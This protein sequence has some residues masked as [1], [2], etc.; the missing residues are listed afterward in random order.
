MTVRYAEHRRWCST[1][2]AGTTCS[3]GSDNTLQHRWIVDSTGFGWEN[4]G[5]SIAG[6]PTVASSAPGRIDV[7]ARD[8]D[9]K[10]KYIAWDGNA[11][12]WTNWR[13]VSRDVVQGTPALVSDSPNHLDVYWR[14]GAD[15]LR[16]A[17]FDGT[18]W[19]GATRLTTRLASDPAVISWGAG[20]VDVFWRA[21]GN[22]LMHRG[23]D[24]STIETLAANLGGKPAVESWGAG[25][26]DV[27]WRGTDDHAY[28]MAFQNRWWPAQDLGGILTADPAV[29]SRSVGG[30]EAYVRGVGN[31]AWYQTYN[32]G[33]S[34]WRSLGGTLAGPPVTISIASNLLGVVALGDDGALYG[35]SFVG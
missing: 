15:A 22:R 8:T 19:S 5:G 17:T 32:N 25:R 29:V 7:I 34:G 21:S 20:R 18:R 30:V 31:G 6:D 27:V 26:I 13:D 16:H 11:G 28:Q 3:R 1:A 9:N 24:A 14:N 23:S 33:W 4:L 2:P 10:L 35:N 12:A